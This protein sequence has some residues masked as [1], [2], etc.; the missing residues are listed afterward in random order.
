MRKRTTHRLLIV[1]L[2]LGIGISLAE[3]V[4]F[5]VDE[6]TSACADSECCF[7]CHGLHASKLPQSSSSLSTVLPELHKFSN[8]APPLHEDPLPFRLER[9]PIAISLN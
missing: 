1:V 4:L 8:V 7:Y 6:A 9:P 2:L 3:D 5:C